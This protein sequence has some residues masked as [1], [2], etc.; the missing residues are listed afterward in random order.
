MLQQG[1]RL[2]PL[3]PPSDP[4][5]LEYKHVH[6]AGKTTYTWESF[7][8]G[9]VEALPLMRKHH[10]EVY[11]FKDTCPFD[12]LWEEYFNLERAGMLHILAV[13]HGGVLVGYMG[14]ILGPMLH[15]RHCIRAR[16]DSYYLDPLF[17]RG[18][19]G[20]RMF[21]EAEIRMKKL[22]AMRIEFVPKKTLDSY[23]LLVKWFLKRG[24]LENETCVAKIL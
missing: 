23:E 7:A 2:P 13:R 1:E 5:K 12:P 16:G 21:I 10:A 3:L 19:T 22:G 15:S 11:D 8:A 14:L 24:Y 20:L 4:A 17:R 18:R 6:E 9:C